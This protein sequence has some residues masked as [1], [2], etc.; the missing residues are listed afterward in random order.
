MGTDVLPVLG[1]IGWLR[2]YFFDLFV[3]T[4]ALANSALSSFDLVICGWRTL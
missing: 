2:K 3:I 1:R 4:Y